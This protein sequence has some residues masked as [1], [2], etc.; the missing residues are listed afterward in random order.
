MD[1]IMVFSADKLVMS[2]LT[3]CMIRESMVLFLPN[4]VAGPHGW[5]IDTQDR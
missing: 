5:L 1:W 4:T 3:L 2:F